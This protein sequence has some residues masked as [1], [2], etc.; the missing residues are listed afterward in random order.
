MFSS[1][2]TVKKLSL[3]VLLLTA[4]VT[5]RADNTAISWFKDLARAS[6]VASKT[7]QPM[8]IEFW[9][10][11]CAAC[12]VMNKDIYTNPR[13]IAAVNSRIVPVRIHF[14]LQKDLARKYNVPALPYIVFTN[15]N[16]TELM[17]H[18][19]ILN[20]EELAAVVRAMPADVSELNRLD[21]ALQEN[22][23]NFESLVAM[24]RGLRAAGFA[25]T[26]NDYY[27][28]A[29]K[30]DDA[31]NYPKER[32]GAL[33]EMGLNFLEL[34]DPKQAAQIFE[35][36]LKEFPQSS[37]R[38]DYLLNLA[39]AHV[40][41]AQKGKARKTLEVLIEEYPQSEASAKA[42]ALLKSL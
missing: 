31:K 38:P 17:H 28:R 41:N 14:D 24:G 13:L 5:S 16:G 22:K 32:E 42:K 36:C 26:S 11:W 21:R 34:Q 15:S 30:H 1:T 3:A 23:N 2:V 39:N 37:N 29:V 40:M 10:D 7:N 20:A 4:A 8:M 18:R 25:S 6:E 33:L 12:Q 27:A 19:G 9:A 35:A